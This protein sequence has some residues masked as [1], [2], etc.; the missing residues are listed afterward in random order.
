[1]RQGAIDLLLFIIFDFEFVVCFYSYVCG[2]NLYKWRKAYYSISTYKRLRTLYV[3]LI[4]K[5]LS[6]YWRTH[7]QLHR[8][9]CRDHRIASYTSSFSYSYIIHNNCSAFGLDPIV[10][11]DVGQMN[12]SFLSRLHYNSQLFRIIWETRRP[13]QIPT[14]NTFSTA[15]LPRVFTVYEQWNQELSSSGWGWVQR[16]AVE[17]YGMAGMSLLR[18]QA[19]RLRGETRPK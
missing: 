10:I 9:K 15:A 7:L 2:H 18:L 4:V 12:I 6:D 17:Q 14:E 1:M 8:I 11:L 3:F 13:K 19:N 16:N 5:T